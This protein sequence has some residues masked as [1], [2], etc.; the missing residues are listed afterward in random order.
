[1][2]I[3]YKNKRLERILIG[4]N[5]VAAVVVAASFV[6]LFGFYEPLLDAEILYILQAALLSVFILEKILRFLNAFSKLE[7]WRGNWY[8]VPFFLAL[9]VVVIGSWRWFGKADPT[10]LRYFAVLF[11]I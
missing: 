6:L 9:A 8:E 4:V 1:M 2:L 5:I 11:S 3:H 10:T 7:Y